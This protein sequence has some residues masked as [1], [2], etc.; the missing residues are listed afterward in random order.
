V[1][2]AA[3]RRAAVFAHPVGRLTALEFRKGKLR[4]TAETP[5]L[6]RSEE[7]LDCEY[8]GEPLR[9]GFNAGYLLEIL[10]HVSSDK[11]VIELSSPL[12]AGLFKPS[13]PKPD[14]EDTYLLMP[15][16]LD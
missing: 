6:G 11:V 12:S 7:E 4:L 2:S 13:E 5:E 14:A 8:S 10:R 9:I 16:R 1:F 3:L 15:I